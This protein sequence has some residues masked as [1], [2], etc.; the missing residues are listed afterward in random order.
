MEKMIKDLFGALYTAYGILVF[1]LPMP[2]VLLFHI[3]ASILP[4]KKRLVRIYKAHSYWIR[5]WTF[6]I[7][8][9]FILENEE[10][11]DPQ[12]S[13]VFV[14]NH[15]N[16]LD[17]AMVGSM[18]FHPWKPLTKKEIKDI[19]LLGW[20]IGNISIV[21][22]R[23]SPQSRSNSLLDMVD[24]LKKGISILIFPEGSRNRKDIPLSKFYPGAFKTAIEAQAPILPLVIYNTRK[25]KPVNE[26]RLYPGKGYVRLL[27]PISTEGKTL[28]DL[29]DLMKE[30]HEIMERQIL[31]LDDTFQTDAGISLAT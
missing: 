19:P 8:T 21:V 12:K 29:E 6:V 18:L 23:R 26:F 9:E 1:I 7:G 25:L 17:V 2:L 20:L 22:D 16:M 4:E 3:Y 14:G 27:D 30:V 13:Y 31:E 28:E 5:F 11:V 10:K 24:H 15:V